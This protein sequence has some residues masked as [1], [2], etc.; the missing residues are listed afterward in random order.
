[1]DTSLR[2]IKEVLIL[3][4]P[5]TAWLLMV[6]LACP[7]MLWLSLTVTVAPKILFA[8]V[9]F[10]WICLLL[11]LVTARLTWWLLGDDT[12]TQHG[13]RRAWWKRFAK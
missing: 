5:L 6:V 8:S 10:P 2:Q 1:M 7:W 12:P 9:E 11:L 4:A 3:I 13:N